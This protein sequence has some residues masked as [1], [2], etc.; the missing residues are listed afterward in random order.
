M[1]AAHRFGSGDAWAAIN[2]DPAK[3]ASFAVP[4]ELRGMRRDQVGGESKT[5]DNRLV[6]PPGEH[7][8]SEHCSACIHCNK[9]RTS[10][11]QG[12]RQRI[13]V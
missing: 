10:H 3:P 12:H 7:W 11:D 8:C 13:I 4:T 9:A 1:G 6:L 2:P 5:F